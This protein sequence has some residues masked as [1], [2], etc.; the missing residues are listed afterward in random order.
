MGAMQAQAGDDSD[1]GRYLLSGLDVGLQ[2]IELLL[3]HDRISIGIVAEHLGIS[4]AAAHRTLRTLEARG[5]AM[6]SSTGRGYLPGPALLTR[7]TIT[8]ISAETRQRLR[9]VLQ[10]ARALTGESVHS[11]VLT[12]DHVLVVDGRRSSH[13]RDIGLRIGMT[14]PAHAMAAGKLLLAALDDQQVLAALP[15]DPLVRRGPNTITSREDLL[16]A[17]RQIRRRGWAEAR[18]ESELGVHS[19]ALPLDGTD[20]RS[21]VVLVASLPSARTR[22]RGTAQIVAGLRSVIQTYA[23]RGVIEPFTLRR[24]RRPAAAQSRTPSRTTA[25]PTPDIH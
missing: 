6:L 2:V 7:A 8:G 22:G 5:F 12:G 23:E 15:P 14:A 4:A 25:A 19:V 3:Q 9:P 10:D 20:W 21:R 13:E 17:L 16:T 24:P 1:G 18:Q 11:A